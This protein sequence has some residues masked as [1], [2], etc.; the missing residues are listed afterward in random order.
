MGEEYV[1][2][3]T[4]DV[5]RVIGRSGTTIRNLQDDSGCRIKVFRNDDGDV[6]TKVQLKGS[7]DTIDC[8]K[9]L[10]SRIT[11]LRVTGDHSDDESRVSGWG[12]SYVSSNQDDCSSKNQTTDD[13]DE[14]DTTATPVT[15]SSRTWSSD[16]MWSSG[17]SHTSGSSHG[18]K[19]G[20]NRR[21][22]KIAD[23]GRG[24]SY[25]QHS[26]SRQHHGTSQF[27]VPDSS[28]T[29][30]KVQI[31]WAALHAGR[32]EAVA[33][34]WKGLPDIVKDFYNEDTEVASLSYSDVEAFRSDRNGISV[35]DLSDKD[36]LIPNPVKTFEQA[37][38]DYPEIID[39][40]YKQEFVHPSPIQCQ[41]WPVLLKGFDMVGIAQTGT[42]KTLAFLLPALIHINGQ[43][44]PRSERSGPTVLVLSPTR[45]L[46]LQ[47]EKEV[48]KFCYKGIRS[49]CVYGGGNR[50]EQIKTVGRGVEI[51]IA[52][53]GRLNDLL[54]NG[55][56]CLR[57][58]TFL[59][60]DEAD[61]MLDMGFEPQIKKVLL[62]IRPDRQTVMTS[63]T[64]PPGVRRLA[65]SYMTDPFQVTV[66][67]LDL[68]ACKAV[69][70]QVEFIEDSDKKERVMEFIND[71]ID[72][73]KV[74]IF[75]S[76]K[77]TADDLASD[78]LLHG[79]PVQSIHGDR[80]QEDREQALEDFSTGAAPIL[81]ATDVASRG[82]DIK[83]ITFVINFDFP[84]HIEDYVHRV[85]RTGRA[86][87]TGK[88]LTFMSRSNWKWA[89]QLIKILSD[90]CQVVP[91]ELVSMAERY[92]KWCERNRDGRRY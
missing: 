87:S 32:A 27:N 74:L 1:Y 2:V 23:R 25:Q 31:D 11:K 45:E 76:R 92:D 82:I 61:R 68:Q 21:Q 85:G 71:M 28:G 63:A 38:R 41:S 5:G 6:Y 44:V 17:S 66:G 60:L 9:N 52:T 55:V 75:C 36:R 20:F 35:V 86:G 53:P 29:E 46:A 8:A 83:D 62:D 89:R 58:V 59:I 47:I 73:E 43:T 13:W 91:L 70:Q 51:V 39:Q 16:M 40:I 69:V 37:F 33:K 22:I 14:P 48:Q 24:S 10:I 12:K 72:G 67:T 26:S 18:F 42:G 77:A 50:K 4:S 15:Q 90:A 80:E 64:W 57:S 84:M 88:A 56:L 34:K 30:R 49:V 3:A 65:E 7:T 81:V 54:M 79:Y 19:S 78:L